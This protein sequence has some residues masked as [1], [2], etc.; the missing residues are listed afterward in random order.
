[1]EGGRSA[2]PKVWA[3][4][5]LALLAT[6]GCWGCSSE[7]AGRR[8]A[9]RLLPAPLTACPYTDYKSTLICTAMAA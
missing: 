2:G 8:P 9:V 4:V 5:S 7:A 6:A 1:M 3:V